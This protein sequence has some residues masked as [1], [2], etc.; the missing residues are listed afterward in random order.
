M[1]KRKEEKISIIVPCFNEEEVLPL[2]YTET[3]KVLKEIKLDYELIFVN[4][5]SKDKTKQVLKDLSIKDDKVIYLN[6]SRNFGK[7]SAMFAG[8]S[9][10]EGDYVVIMDADLQHPPF[11]IKDMLSAIREKNCDCVTA[12]RVTRDGDSKITTWFAR[13]FYKFISHISYVEMKD[14]AG[15]FRLMK[16]EVVEALLSMNEY[17]RFS[18]GMF[19]W[20]GFNNYYLEYNNVE[21]AAG[22]TSW[23]FIGLV[24]YAINGIVDFSNYPLDLATFIGTLTSASAFI[25]LIVILIKYALYGDPV[26]GWPTLI[27]V[28]LISGGLNLL[29]L[30]VLGQYI[31]KIYMETKNRPHYIIADSNKKN[32]VKIK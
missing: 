2:F 16:K 7:E 8:L 22:K 9:N 25:Y 31:G 27:C 29:F 1:A 17:N 15:D 6:F 5:G 23:N 10:A 30:G 11:M 24:K 13:E 3:K 19:S 32:A 26:S 12:R 4:D 18:K 28:I 21:R 14:G 20:V